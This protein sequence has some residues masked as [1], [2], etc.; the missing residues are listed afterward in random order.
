MKV[1]QTRINAWFTKHFCL[2]P[3]NRCGWLRG[4]II[5]DTIDML[6]LIY[7]TGRNLI[8]HLIGDSC[9]IG[10]HEVGCG[11]AAQGN[12]I[13]VGTE[14]AHNANGAHICDNREILVNVSVQT[15]LCDFLSENRIRILLPRQSRAHPDRD[16]GRA[17]DIPDIPA[18]RAP[19]PSD[20]PHP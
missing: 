11:Y 19:D 14:V 17:D 6:Y 13:I 8:Q 15:C 3:F 20:V 2:F 4:D 12:G 9:P 5:H 18:D 7:D 10:S 1:P 16:R